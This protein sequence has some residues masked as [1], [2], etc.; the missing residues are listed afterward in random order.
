MRRALPILFAA[1]VLSACASTNGD[2]PITDDDPQP[3]DGGTGTAPDAVLV[4]EPGMTATGPGISV[5]DALDQ[6]GGE[7]VLVNGALFID[8]E[9]VVLLCDAIAESFPPQCGGARLL[10]EGAD[11]A[12]MPDLEEANGVRWSESVQLL[13]RVVAGR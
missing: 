7:P 13:G 11:L 4:V 1:I 12:T 9:G 8:P 6:V 2:Q 3:A 10:V 5:A